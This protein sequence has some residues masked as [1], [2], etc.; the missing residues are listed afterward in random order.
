MLFGHGVQVWHWGCWMAH[1]S[2]QALLKRISNEIYSKRNCRIR[3]CK[4]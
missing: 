1:G 3:E 2:S 4:D